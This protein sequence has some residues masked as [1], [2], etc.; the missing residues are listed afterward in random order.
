[1]RA[2]AKYV[3]AFAAAVSLA[4]AV[5]GG[6]C[7]GSGSPS[8]GSPPNPT[9]PDGDKFDGGVTLGTRCMGTV[10]VTGTVG[11][12]FC[13]DGVWAYTDTDPDWENDIFTGDDATE[14]ADAEDGASDGADARAPDAGLVDAASR[15]GR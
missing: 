13:D 2:L 7:G 3:W 6:A 12:A 11:Y 15:D 8:N 5:G 4:G 10:F 14:D 1:V 9:P